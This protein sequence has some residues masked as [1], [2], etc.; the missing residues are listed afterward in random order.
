MCCYVFL[1]PS[2]KM[3]KGLNTN[4]FTTFLFLIISLF[5]QL[6]VSFSLHL[7]LYCAHLV[8]IIFNI[9]LLLFCSIFVFP[10]MFAIV[11]ELWPAS[12][13]LVSV[14]Y[15]S[16]RRG[17]FHQQRHVRIRHQ[18]VPLCRVVTER[19]VQHRRSV[20]ALHSALPRAARQIQTTSKA[21]SQCKIYFIQFNWL[22]TVI[23]NH[24]FILTRGLLS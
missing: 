19:R 18:V 14:R 24:N 12:N 5:S 21:A 20:R 3:S 8:V 10:L 13:D 2:T 15:S 22:E 1:P 4:H 7:S 9:S 11:C 23:Y 16:K 6:N 17:G